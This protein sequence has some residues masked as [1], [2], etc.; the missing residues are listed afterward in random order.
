MSSTEDRA[1]EDLILLLDSTRSAGLWDVGAP[2]LRA[3]VL[4]RPDGEEV[5]ALLESGADQLIQ[6]VWCW[7][8]A[9]HEQAGPLP[10][11]LVDAIH[12]R[13]RCGATTRSGA[14]CRAIVG[15]PG[16]RCHH[17]RPEQLAFDFGGQR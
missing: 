4:V 5:L 16:R 3:A 2:E 15:G 11:W 6:D 10:Q 1:A 13:F 9:P 8:R 14:P 7:H 12:C 17:H